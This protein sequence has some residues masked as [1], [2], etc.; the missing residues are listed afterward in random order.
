[1]L[2]KGNTNP[3]LNTGRARESDEE[4]ADGLY[5]SK[6]QESSTYRPSGLIKSLCWFS[7]SVQTKQQRTKGMPGDGG[8]ICDW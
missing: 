3:L 5:G 6:S 7:I 2:G 8:F 1:M 4:L